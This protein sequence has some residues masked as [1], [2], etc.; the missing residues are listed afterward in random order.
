MT[1]K[2]KLTR[3]SQ[4]DTVVIKQE[5][6]RFFISTPNSIIIDKAGYLWLMEVLIKSGFINTK[7]VQE[8]ALRLTAFGWRKDNNED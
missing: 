6:G 8:V 3:L 5:G 7:D 2:L 4:L 1:L